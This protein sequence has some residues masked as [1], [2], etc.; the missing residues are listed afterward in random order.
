MR[1][2]KI[3]AIAVGIGRIESEL[4]ISVRVDPDRC[5]GTDE[6]GRVA[7][8]GIDARGLSIGRI[9]DDRSIGFSAGI[10]KWRCVIS[11]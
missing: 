2:L 9:R 4:E 8:G 11:L 6:I 5:T 10:R 1:D 7:V 3:P